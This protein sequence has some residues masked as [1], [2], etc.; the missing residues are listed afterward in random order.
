MV[1]THLNGETCTGRSHVAVFAVPCALIDV[2][3]LSVAFIPQVQR[4]VRYRTCE[5]SPDFSVQIVTTVERCVRRLFHLDS[6]HNGCATTQFLSHTLRLGCESVGQTLR[7]SKDTSNFA[8]WPAL[9]V[10]VDG[11]NFASS[12]ASRSHVKGVAILCFI[13]NFGRACLPCVVA[14]HATFVL[15][16]GDTDPRCCFI[17][18]SEQSMDANGKRCGLICCSRILIVAVNQ[19]AP[20]CAALL[21]LVHRG[22]FLAVSW[23]DRFSW[24]MCELCPLINGDV[25]SWFSCTSHHSGANRC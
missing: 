16:R 7:Q 6:H 19:F 2:P 22:F 11:P 1:W 20:F 5:S 9:C 17:M 15:N 14:K 21:S 12:C 8:L 13:V 3:T 10:A 18:W 23:C 24:N 4:N 25:S